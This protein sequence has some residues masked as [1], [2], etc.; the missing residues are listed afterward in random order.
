M[1]AHAKYIKNVVS[2]SCLGCSLDLLDVATRAWNTEYNPKKFSPVIIRIKHTGSTALLF[3]SGQ[4]LC[5]SGVSVE[6]NKRTARK[7]ARIIQK[8]GYPVIF[9]K[10]RVHNI[11]AACDVGFKICLKS[12]YTKHRQNSDYEPEIFPGLRYKM[13]KPNLTL[14][15]FTSGKVNM[16]GL[17]ETSDIEKA[18]EKMM[19]LL[20]NF[21]VE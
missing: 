20:K 18:Y 16:V 1:E 15:I 12:L 13:N 19:V 2:T 4:L 5:I 14:K 9:S 10:Y 3:N 21:M 7:Y 8:L 6:H 11:V 17:R